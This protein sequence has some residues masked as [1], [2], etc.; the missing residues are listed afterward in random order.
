MFLSAL[1]FVFFFFVLDPIIT[2]ILDLHG[3][4]CCR[5]EVASLLLF[6]LVSFLLLLFLVVVVRVVAFVVVVV[7]VVVGT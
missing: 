3:V 4:R 2:L 5:A 1:V 7:V 6:F